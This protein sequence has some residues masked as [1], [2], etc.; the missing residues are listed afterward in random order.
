MN[1]GHVKAVRV[2]KERVAAFTS[3]RDVLRDKM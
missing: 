2:Y 1:E 3:E